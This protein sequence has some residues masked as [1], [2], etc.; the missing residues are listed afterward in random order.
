MS[1]ENAADTLRGYSVIL[2]WSQRSGEMPEDWKKANITSVFR[3]DKKENLGSYYHPDSPTSIPG[4]VE[5]LLILEDIP[6]HMDDMK[7]IRIVSMNH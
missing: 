1:A 3:N 2:E 7:V 4:K 5:E 6:I